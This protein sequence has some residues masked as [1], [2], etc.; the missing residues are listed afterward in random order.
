MK[1]LYT[2]RNKNGFFVVQIHYTADPDKDPSTP[3]GKIWYENARQ[4]MP[5]SS[6]RKEYEIDWF[7][8]SGELIYP[9]FDPSV[10]LIDPFPI[11]P[12]WTK[13]MAIDP[14]LRNP[15]AILWAAVD[16]ENNV[17]IYDEYYVPEKTV[18]WHI[19]EIKKKEKGAKIYRRLIDPS[20]ASRN[21][22]N[23]KTIIDEYK[24]GGIYCVP[25]NND[26][27]AGINRVKEYLKID[28][29]TSLPSLFFFNTL[30]HTLWEIAH[31]RWEKM[32][33]EKIV[34]KNPP[35]KPVKKGD[36]LMDCLRY[37]LMD[38]PHYVKEIKI[39]P[40]TPRYVWDGMTTG[41]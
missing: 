24:R 20:S 38:D 14:G 19:Q 22:I 15:T 31:Y 40:H 18:H 25:A 5:E 13:Y 7:A 11:P 36:H 23:K 29:K 41:Y 9:S 37:I 3:H 34:L 17:Y 32:D 27:E 2:R 8:N 10:H 33:P 1:G 39:L 26:L 16:K 4:G 30:S 21:P 12:D 28:P 35:E 6:W